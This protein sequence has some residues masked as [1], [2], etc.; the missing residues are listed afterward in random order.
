[1]GRQRFEPS[2]EFHKRPQRKTIEWAA[3]M[4]KQE[5]SRR[6]DYCPSRSTTMI[7]SILKIG[8][9]PKALAAVLRMNVQSIYN[10]IQRRGFSPGL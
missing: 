10:Q 2:D 1:M 8:I 7:F 9:A 6:E 3:A 4:K 5:L